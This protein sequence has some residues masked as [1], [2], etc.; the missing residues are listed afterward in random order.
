MNFW[1]FLS[2]RNLMFSILAYKVIWP[3]GWISLVELYLKF[4]KL[5]FCHY[6]VIAQLHFMSQ[7]NTQLKTG[8]IKRKHKTYLVLLEQKQL[9]QE[10][11]SFNDFGTWIIF[12]LLTWFSKTV[13]SHPTLFSSCTNIVKSHFINH[14]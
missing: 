14:K 9:D 13:F 8:I 11:I 6:L 12:A 3:F 1:F 2:Y 5:T 7:W 4:G 10:K